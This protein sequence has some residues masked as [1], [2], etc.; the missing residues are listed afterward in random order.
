MEKHSIQDSAERALGVAFGGTARLA[1]ERALVGG[2]R[3]RV[4]RFRVF[5]GPSSAPTSVIVKKALAGSS[6]PYGLVNEWAGLQFLDDIAGDLHLAPRFY[7]GDLTAGLIVLEDLGEGMGLHDI[8]QGRDPALARE[9]L[10]QL[11]ATLGRM[12]ALTIGKQRQYARIR[13]TLGPP[14]SVEVLTATEA[15]VR[16]EQLPTV[17]RTTAELLGVP[18]T[19]GLDAD[20]ELITRFWDKPGPFLAYTHTDPCPDNCLW[21]D[22]TVKL[23]DFEFGGFHHAVAEGI[24]SRVPFPT[25]W[26]FGRLP[27]DVVLRMEATYR[28]EL[29]T[30]CPEAGDDELFTRAIVEAC[31]YWTVGMFHWAMPGILD[32]DET[33]GTATLRQRVL[34]RL[35]VLARTAQELRHLEAFGQTAQLMAKRFRELWSPEVTEPPYYPAFQ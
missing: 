1:D 12:H 25:C 20:L 15:A 24:Y 2:D 19:S 32:R 33:W 7:A 34:V 21:R 28:A 9:A 23:L 6:S 4:Y 11:A 13:H 31:A 18:T 3:H 17:F 29:V 8:L 30:G 10:V 26:C 16:P 22:R 27:D 5:D 14:P 35:D